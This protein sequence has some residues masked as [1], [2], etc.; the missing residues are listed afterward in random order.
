MEPR[1]NV[2]SGC[3]GPP[4]VVVSLP[5]S[6]SCCS[7]R[8]PDVDDLSF[9]N[10]PLELNSILVFV[11]HHYA[12]LSLCLL[13]RHSFGVKSQPLIYPRGFPTKEEKSLFSAILQKLC[14]NTLLSYPGTIT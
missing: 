13:D 14:Q 9:V 5:S 1:E 11:G 6:K 8:V 7:I 10:K 12:F 3:P 2:G 4:E